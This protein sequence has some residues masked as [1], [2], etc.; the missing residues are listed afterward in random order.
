VLKRCH[1]DFP[2]SGMPL[3]LTGNEII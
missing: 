1:D 3:L 2:S